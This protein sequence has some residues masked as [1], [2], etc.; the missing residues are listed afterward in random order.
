ML[1]VLLAFIF[2]TIFG[3]V[4]TYILAKK[5][6]TTDNSAN[7]SEQLKITT[8]AVREIL[9]SE[10]ELSSKDLEGKKE[11]IDSKLAD[12][13]RD[14]KGMSN[15][16]KDLEQ[17]R[18]EQ[19]AELKTL[20]NSSSQE[21]KN[22]IDITNKLNN[23]L[24]SKQDRG[25]WAERMAFDIL[26]YA[27]MIEGINYTRQK[28]LVTGSRP[29]FTFLLP[30]GSKLNMDVKFPLENYQR[31]N[32]AADIDKPKFKTDFISSIKRHIRDLTTR[33]YINPEDNTL[34]SVIMFI[35]NERIYSTIFEADPSILNFAI[36]NRVLLCSPVTIISILSV[37]RQAADNFMLEQKA[38]ELLIAMGS[39]RKEWEKYV[40]SFDKLGD[41]ILKVSDQ[42][43]A[44]KTTRSRQLDRSV[45]RLEEL[46][47]RDII[48]S[49]E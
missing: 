20:V 31:Y 30:N 17:K 46:K 11:L 38:K 36:D 6:F 33:E 45:K 4:V 18:G 44:L 3:V 47:S 15:L 26:S 9:L 34:D 21:T 7:I 29:D 28:Q 13:D 40:D 1:Y 19:L 16:V 23:T 49:P 41:S 43:N 2:G 48:E 37:I 10:R 32:N 35:P 14:L 5:I 8:N 22:L 12:I 42:Y 27:G 24:S 25:L 39:F